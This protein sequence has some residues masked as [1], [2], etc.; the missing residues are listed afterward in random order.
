MPGGLSSPT[1]AGIRM[2]RLPILAVYKGV[3]QFL[4]HGNE[5]ENVGAGLVPALGDYKGSPLRF[6]GETLCL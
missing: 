6:S 2:R 3:G 4:R 1:P 5:D